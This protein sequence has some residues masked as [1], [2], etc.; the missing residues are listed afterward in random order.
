MRR[1]MNKIKQAMDYHKKGNWQQ[2]DVTYE[3]IIHEEPENSDVMY[4]LATSQM[5]QNKLEDSLITINKAI[6]L[7]DKAPAFQQLKG[8]ILAR[9][10]H[11]DEA[12]KALKV[13]IKGNPNLYQ[14]H[15]FIGHIYYNKGKKHDAENHFRLA[16]KIDIKQTEAQI[17]LARIMIDVGDIQNAIIMLRNME[18][19]HPDEVSV[20]MMMGQAFIESG[21]YNFAENYFKKVLAMHPKYDL[22]GLYLGIAK[23]QKGDTKSAESLILEFNKHYPNT[24]ETIAALG[25]LMY[26]KNR[27]NSAASYLGKAISNGLA[28]MSWKGTY[29]ESLAQ[30]GQRKNAIEFYKNIEKKGL[31]KFA[32]NRLGELYELENKPKKAIKKYLKTGK[33]ESKYIAALLGLGR[34]YLK[35]ENPE[36]AETYIKEVLK[37]EPQHAEATLLILT[38]HMFQNKTDKALIKL[39]TLDYNNYD[40]AYK[41]SFRIQ[42][43]LILDKQ[44]KYKQAMEVYKD[45]SKVEKENLHKHRK[46]TEKEV[47]KISAFKSKIDDGLKDPVFIMGSPAT[48]INRFIFWLNNQGITILNDRLMTLGR[49]D[50]L[51]ALLEVDDLSKMDDDKVRKERK[52]YHQKAKKMMTGL[53]EGKIFAD[54]IYINTFQVAIIKKF[55]PQAKIILLNRNSDDIWLNQQAF[56][57]EPINSSD[58]H[59]TISQIEKME[60]NLTK[61]NI[62]KWIDNDKKTLKKI[63]KIFDKDLE[64]TKEP[65]QK[66]WQKTF[67]KKGH[68]KKYKKS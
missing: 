13:A 64:V 9:M 16:M 20:K 65:K 63:S 49:S 28:P 39:K 2:A 42:H 57:K 21:A 51:Y 45:S 22:A 4:L 68:W 5:S 58:W 38:A 56:G 10:G 40:E 59:N 46:L 48:Q 8:S 53:K 7:N 19:E 62:D 18:Q 26:K 24:K 30:M 6:D 15:I 29:A 37:L 31:N 36:K 66:Y 17:N 27:F 60:L 14:S 23:L 35:L 54:T 33:D 3:E 50:I 12:L 32:S 47:K 55:F 67:F 61:V 43:A 1:I 44:K 52:T 25:L 34:C 41:R 11:E